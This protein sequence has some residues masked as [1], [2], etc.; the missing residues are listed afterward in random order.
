MSTQNRLSEALLGPVGDGS[1][2]GPPD[3][4]SGGHLPG[5]PPIGP[6]VPPQAWGV[7]L[8]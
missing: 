1:R 7:H 6:L 8:D 5:D 2:P 4:S 3:S